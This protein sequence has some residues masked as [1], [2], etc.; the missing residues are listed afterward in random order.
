MNQL[1]LKGKSMK[2]D[3]EMIFACSNC[4]HEFRKLIPWGHPAEG[5]GG[6]CE[7]CGIE[8]C[9]SN[10]Y[11][12]RKPKTEDPSALTWDFLSRNYRI[13]LKEKPK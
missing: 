11:A 5:K 1:K 2:P 8:D 6:T 12:Y 13:F 3:Y 4:G 9:S 10:P 7:Y